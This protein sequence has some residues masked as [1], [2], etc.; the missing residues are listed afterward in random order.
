MGETGPLQQGGRP[1][2]LLVLEGGRPGVVTDDLAVGGGRPLHATAAPVARGADARVTAGGTGTAQRGT[3][4]Q[5]AVKDGS[6]GGRTH[7]LP[8][9][10]QLLLGVP[11]LESAG[12]LVGW[13]LLPVR[14]RDGG[15]QVDLMLQVGVGGL[16]AVEPVPLGEG[17]HGQAVGGPRWGID[18]WLWDSTA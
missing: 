15:W 11:Q 13:G 10:L 14:Q 8:V 3:V 16:E 12:A 9:Q 4:H 17:G 18:L 5:V 7:R 6:V 2:A 1:A